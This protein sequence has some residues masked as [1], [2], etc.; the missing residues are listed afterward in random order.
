MFLHNLVAAQMKDFHIFFLGLN[1]AP[2]ILYGCDFTLI[3]QCFAGFQGIT[4]HHNL[5]RSFN[6]CTRWAHSVRSHL[7][8]LS[9]PR[10][11]HKM[12]L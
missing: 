1:S 5:E 11:A 6:I 8:P 10:E 4:V 9:P 12:L 3:K 2:V 7:T